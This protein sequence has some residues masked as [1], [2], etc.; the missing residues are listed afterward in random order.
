MVSE[1]SFGKKATTRLMLYI[2]LVVFVLF[3]SYFV[4]GALV[5]AAT[6]MWSGNFSSVSPSLSSFN[7]TWNE[8]AANVST[9][10]IEGN[11]T[12]I[13]NYTASLIDGNS[14]IGVWNYYS[15]LPAGTFYWKSY[16]S[17][18]QNFWNTTPK[19]TFTVISSTSPL[20]NE[21]TF[22][23]G[24]NALSLTVQTVTSVSPDN[25]NAGSA[26][27]YAYNAQTKNWDSYSVTQLVGGRGYWFYSTNSLQCDV[28][29]NGQ[30]SISASDLAPLKAGYNLVGTKTSAPY[31]FASTQGSCNINS[32]PIYWD[33]Q[34]QR[35]VT[36]VNLNGNLEANRAYWV[37]VSSDCSFV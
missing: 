6:P 19:W 2:F 21:V 37:N 22:Y 28:T 33:S 12:G 24:W 4:R 15:T 18:T 32:N 17:N 9:V 11:W 30:G 23:P 31:S 34:N 14:K 10:F 26:F 7:I 25:C 13:R 5:F 35:F 3:Y 29:F 20:T 36:S 8:T 16:A 1:L 27:F